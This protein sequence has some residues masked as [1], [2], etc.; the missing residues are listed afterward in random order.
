MLLL[1]LLLLAV[2]LEAALRLPGMTLPP[3]RERPNPNLLM[4]VVERLVLLISPLTGRRGLF[5]PR[6]K[7]MVSRSDPKGLWVHW[8]IDQLID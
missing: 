4:G 6:R 7:D 2:V 1:L 3:A 8:S 5:P